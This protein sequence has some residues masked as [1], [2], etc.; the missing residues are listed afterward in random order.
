MVLYQAQVVNKTQ[1]NLE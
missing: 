1:V